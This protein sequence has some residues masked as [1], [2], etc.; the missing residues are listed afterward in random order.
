MV[1][2]SDMNPDRLLFLA[3][4]RFDQYLIHITSMNGH[5]IYS[6]EMEG[7]SIQV[8]ISSFRNG[9]YLI[10]IRSKESVTTRKI[11]KL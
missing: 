10:T 7:T 4:D 1:K 9:V 3:T 5:F 8:D 11:M 2:N 6:T